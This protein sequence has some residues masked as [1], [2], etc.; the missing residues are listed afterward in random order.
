MQR[1]SSICYTDVQ[2]SRPIL[3]EPLSELL[4]PTLLCR[5]LTLSLMHCEVGG[6]ALLIPS[7][8]IVDPRFQLTPAEEATVVFLEESDE[9]GRRQGSKPTHERCKR[10]AEDP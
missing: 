1:H 2:H 5:C 3:F 4:K 8:T 6:S 10:R 7:L 9:M